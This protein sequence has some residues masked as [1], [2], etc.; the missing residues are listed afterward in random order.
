MKKSIKDFTIMQ[1]VLVLAFCLLVIVSNETEQK[2]TKGLCILLSCLIVSCI[3]EIGHFFTAM[4]NKIPICGMGFEL[5]WIVLRA[6][7]K[8]NLKGVSKSKIIFFY[9]G[10]T[11]GT[12]ILLLILILLNVIYKIDF[13]YVKVIAFSSIM[14]NI[15]PIYKND[16]YYILKYIN[17]NN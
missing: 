1:V 3:H 16:G 6:Y 11:I 8:V 9:L 5:R 13:E 10:G 7:T 15:I 4:I 12:G 2:Y 14:I 17:N